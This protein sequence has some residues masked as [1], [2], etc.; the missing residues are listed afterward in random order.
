MGMVTLTEESDC[1]C[2]DTLVVFVGVACFLLRVGEDFGE[3]FG[4]SLGEVLSGFLSGDPVM[5]L[6]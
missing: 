2:D 4:D 1:F 6:T 5:K 3:D